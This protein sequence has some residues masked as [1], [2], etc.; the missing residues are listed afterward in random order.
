MSRAVSIFVFS[1]SCLVFG[2][3]SSPQAVFG[4]ELGFLEEFVL[5]KDRQAVLKKLVPGTEPYYYF[6]ALHHQ[7]NEQL[8]KVDELLKPWI[9]RFGETQRVKQIKNRQ[10]LLKY[11]DDPKVTLDYLKRQLSLHFTHQRQIPDAQRD[12]PTKLDP[13]IIDLDA[14]IA[15]A[16]RRSTV[17]KLSDSGLRLV[18]DKRLTKTQLRNLLERL[19]RPDFPNVVELIVKDLK[20]RDSRGFGK[21]TIHRLLTIKQLDD[22]LTKQPKLQTNS[23]FVEV[24]LS[25]LHPSADVDWRSDREEHRAFLNRLWSFVKTLNANNN[26]LKAC[27]LYRLLELDLR[28]GKYDRKLFMEYLQLP[29]RIA[30]VNPTWLK[31][32]STSNNVANLNQNFSNQIMLLPVRNDEPLIQK[33]LHHFLLNVNNFSAFTPYVR[34]TYLKRQF[35]TVKIINGKGDTEKW[36]SMLSPE[37]YKALMERIDVDFVST[38]PE[39]FDIDDAVE[40]ELHLKNVDNLIVKVFEMNTS[41]YYRKHKRE[42]DTDVNLDGLVPNH[43]ETFTYSDAPALRNKRSFKFPQIKD[44][45]VYIVDFIAGGKSSRALIR[46]GRMQIHGQ[47]TPGGQQFTVV[48]QSGSVVT[49]ANIWIAGTRYMADKDGKILV[50]FSTQPGRVNAIISQ[51]EFSCLQSINHVAENYKFTA[52]LVLDRENLLRSNTAKVLI[53]P[54]LQ[55]VGGNPVPVS[56]LEN[57]KLYITTVNQDGVSSTKTISGL[58]LSEKS[59]TI[60]EFVVPP[61]VRQITAAVSAELEKVSNGKKLVFNAN[62]SFSINGIDLSETIQ[63]LHLIPSNRGYFIEVLGKTGELRPKQSVRVEFRFTETN[64]KVYADLQSGA[65]GLIELGDLPGVYQIQ[66]TLARGIKKTWNLMRQDQS[67]YSSIHSLASDTIELAAPAGVVESSRDHVSLLE[68]RN[69]TYVADHFESVAI[70]DGLVSISGLNPGDYEL[71]LTYDSELGSAKTKLVKIRVTEGPR[72]GQVLVGKHRHLET[73]GG[74]TIHVSSIDVTTKQ[75]EIQVDNADP[76]TRVHVIG[77]RYLPVLNA[78]GEFDKVRDLEPWFRN[79][80]LRRSVYMEGRK[81]GD[82]YEYILRRKY[83]KRFPG[84]MLKRPSLLLNPWSTRVTNNDSQVAAEGNDYGGVGSERDKSAGRSTTNLSRQARASDFANLDF[85]GEGSVIF[86][87]LKP[88]ENGVVLVDRE[89]LGPNQHVRVIALNAFHTI[90][91]TVNLPLRKLTPQDGRLVHSLDPDQHFSQS[92]QV[93]VL[94]KGDTLAVD[95]IISAKFQQ[96]D[97]LGDVFKLYQA[98]NAGT[99]LSQFRFILDWNDKSQKEKQE[100]YSKFAC[101]ELNFFIMQKDAN[102]FDEVVVPHLK[103]KRDKTFMDLYL[104]DENLEAFLKPWKFNQLNTVEKIL[105]SHRFETRATDLARHIGESY[106]LNPTPTATFDYLYETTLYGLGLERSKFQTKTLSDLKKSDASKDLPEL[107]AAMGGG[108]GMGRGGGRSQSTPRFSGGAVLGRNPS[109]VADEMMFDDDEEFEIEESEAFYFD[110]KPAPGRGRRLDELGVVN[111]KKRKLAEIAAKSGADKNKRQLNAPVTAGVRVETRTRTVPVQRLRTETRTRKLPDGTIENYTVQVPYT[112]NVT[113][114]YA[115]PVPISINESDQMLRES[116]VELRK[117]TNRLYR[118]IE[119][120]REWMENNYYLLQPGQISSDLVQVNRFW[121]DFASHDGGDFLSPYFAEA[122]RTFTEQMFALSVLDLPL[123]SPE[124]DFEYV[125]SSMTFKSGGPAIVLH[126]Q[127]RDAILERKN[128]TV[129]VSENFYQKN[130]RYRYEDNLRYDKFITGDFLAHTL[131]G[132]QVVI[133][134]PTSTP[135]NID[136]LVQIPK[137]SVACSGSQETK[138]VPMQLGPYSTINVEYSFYFPTAG[139]FSHYPAHVS[140]KE[141]VLAIADPVTF[142]VI[143][144]PAKVDEASWEFVSQNG[145]DEQVID[146]LNQENVLRLNLSMIAFRLNDEKFFKRAISTLRSRY[147][148][149]DTVWSYGIHHNDVS[150][151]REFMDHSRFVPKFGVSFDS[152]LLTVDP[153]ER[154]WYQHKEYWPLVNARAHQLGP[155]RKILNSSFYQQYKSLL[156]VLA[157]RQALNDEDHLAV[158]YYLLLQDRIESALDHFDSVNKASIVEQIQYDYCDA[159]LDMYRE[160]PEAAAAKAEKWKDYP[161]DHWRNRFKQIIAQV[162]GIRNARTGV[163]DDK[164]QSEQQ[165]ELAS[166]SESFDFEIESGVGKLKYRNLGSVQ[167]NYYE[168]DIELLFSRSPFAQDELEGFS[169]IRPN[170]TQTIKLT[171]NKQ[172]KGSKEFKLP[173]EMMNKNV[174][175]EVVA[176]DQTK[177]LPFFAH[178]LDVQMV[179]RFGQLQVTDEKSD[180]PISKTYVKVYARSTNG[181]VRFHKDGYTDLRG[182][183]DYVSQ[184]NQS[185]DDVEKFAVL[186]LS[187]E[188]GAVVRQAAKPKE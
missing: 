69:N 132:G 141:K 175:V 112:E 80:S 169:L 148:Y 155:K 98:L 106:S 92:K 9:K 76:F 44:R 31:Q 68:L 108:G 118:R 177:A 61:R 85:L 151:I 36:A 166:N 170:S 1:I 41:N 144:E 154:N 138:T 115:V 176:G 159:Y 82:E 184:S 173:K 104:L 171:K 73:R 124:H 158:T 60:V 109:V 116:L 55:I 150:V 153:V 146:F 83:A 137:G 89:K 29:K 24:Y 71:N 111:G 143:D 57:G 161:V 81:I 66:A 84:N 23:A 77:T 90:Q 87:N 117:N 149:D 160:Q 186:V 50:P 105:L 174:L 27:V 142:K 165:T 181:S 20:E 182:R 167:V 96:Y 67:F 119:P 65:N 100:L 5:A 43:E 162:D 14:R 187:D 178:S 147:V 16:L 64:D 123:D 54:S 10:A 62:R 139:D 45:G 93:D 38:N 172:G 107:S 122:H 35:A 188:N 114:S 46:K 58:E 145:T 78:Y 21:M 152:E 110:Q 17:E 28:E 18:A 135:R 134:N 8:D 49:D 183:F 37:E 140:A 39:F 6:H 127:V 53:R 91:R 157:N 121:R 86:A 120:T 94:K 164:D 30:Y 72:A 156:N 25:K 47:V 130:D 26:S 22:L 179:E 97:D 113:Q 102:F 163:V 13:K 133:T 74:K 131:Y 126:Q 79:P 180:K 125:D 52:S 136:V 51:G 101:H 75:V 2:W 33:Y 40:L 59:E 56:M 34:D 12:L 88:D 103:N 3:I 11:T 129:L 185:F 95:D 4:Q 48:D 7:N 168:M 99:H 128:T 63:D 15:K 19:T 70:E 42:I 32:V